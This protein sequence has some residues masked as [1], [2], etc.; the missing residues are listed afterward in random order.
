MDWVTLLRD[1]VFDSDPLLYTVVII[2]IG[3][4]ILYYVF[5]HERE[6]NKKHANRPW[7]PFRK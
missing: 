2:C 6:L 3:V 1:Q 7:N 5:K 4:C